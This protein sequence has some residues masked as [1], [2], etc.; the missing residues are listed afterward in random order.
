MVCV[1]INPAKIILFDAVD[2]RV[3]FDDR[4][5]VHECT[6]RR[7]KHVKS[8]VPVETVS[9]LYLLQVSIAF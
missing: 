2:I 7:P 9:I 5:G 6:E 4:G 1:N 3:I 8:S